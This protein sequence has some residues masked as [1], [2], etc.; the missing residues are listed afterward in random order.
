V[1]NETAILH[2]LFEFGSNLWE[3]TT[4]GLIPLNMI[5]NFPLDDLTNRHS[6]PE[7]RAVVA[8][9]LQKLMNEPRSLKSACRLTITKTMGRGYFA[10]IGLL[11]KTLPATLMEFLSFDDLKL[12]ENDVGDNAEDEESTDDESFDQ[13]LVSTKEKEKTRKKATKRRFSSNF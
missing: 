9:S 8:A 10:K 5:T 3:A 13:F 2:L 11:E 4:E 1:K 7:K 6:P 12:E